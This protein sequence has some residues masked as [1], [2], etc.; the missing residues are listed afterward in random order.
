MKTIESG[1]DD[2][3]LDWA[4]CALRTLIECGVRHCVV[5]PGSRSA[6]LVLAAHE[7]HHILETTV[8]FDERGAAFYALGLALGSAGPVMMITTSGTAV[9]NTLPAVVEASLSHVPLLIC[10]ADRPPELRDTEA[11]QSIDQADLLGKHAR[12]FLDMP[13]PTREIEHTRFLPSTIRHAVERATQGD[14]GP[15]HLNFMFREPLLPAAAQMSVAE[16]VLPCVPIWSHVLPKGGLSLPDAV[17][18]CLRTSSRGLLLVGQLATA[19]ERNAAVNLS[20]ALGWP[21]LADVTSGVKHACGAPTLIAHYDLLLRDE[22][23]SGAMQPDLVIHLGGRIVSKSL[24]RFLAQTSCSSYIICQP[25][26]RRHDPVH[27]VT[28]TCV[29]DLA[30][31]CAALQQCLPDTSVDRTWLEGWTGPDGRIAEALD[32][33]IGQ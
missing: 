22:T 13:C 14:P 1:I 5:C 32:A 18:Q 2:L 11:N 16:S 28:H 15:V 25:H 23:F 19:P 31:L 29:G 24:H 8:H 30:A 26:P 27:R 17:E 10:S 12:W 3:N 21:V 20:A 7:Q 4:R 6:P 33:V 9:A